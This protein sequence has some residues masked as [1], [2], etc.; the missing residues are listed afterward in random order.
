MED[1]SVFPDENFCMYLFSNDRLYYCQ[2]ERELIESFDPDRTGSYYQ[3][4]KAVNV[5]PQKNADA[6][7]VYVYAPSDPQPNGRVAL[8]LMI[9]DSAL[10]VI[11]VVVLIS[12]LNR[13]VRNPIRKLVEANAILSKGNY[14][15]QL[16][17]KDAGSSEFEELF[18]S[19]NRMSD[20]IGHLTIESYDLKIKREHNRLK[21]LRAQMKPHT[22]LN[23]I[24]TIS[25]MTYTGRAEDIRKYIA[26]FAAFTRYMLNTSG[27]WTTVREEISHIDNYVKMQQIRFPESIEISYNVSP[28]V[29]NSRIPY[30]VLF[31]LVENSFK[32]AMT[33]VKTMYVTI[34]GERYA[35][36]GFTGIRLIEEDNGPGFTDTALIEL[37]EAETGDPYAKEHL[38]LTNVRYSLNLIYGRD[39][40][41]RLSNNPDGGARIELLI[42]DEEVDD[43]TSGM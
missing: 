42:P 37:A 17:L 18:S 15:Y 8:V 41:L 12:M 2:G 19:F 6:L 10:C 9:L 11:L 34:T 27:D 39:D 29:R 14:E 40:L 36:D 24:S 38:G 13:K 35:E 22:F 20:Q 1:V 32:H 28:N 33:L 43:E 23:A 3:D 4:D 25:N 31:S 21:M 5:V 30:L 16:D 7:C 26:A